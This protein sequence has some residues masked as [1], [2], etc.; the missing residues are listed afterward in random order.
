MPWLYSGPDDKV[1]QLRGIAA[2]EDCTQDGANV[3]SAPRQFWDGSRDRWV[4]EVSTRVDPDAVSD[5]VL[6]SLMR[7]LLRLHRCSAAVLPLCCCCASGG[8]S[9]CETDLL[10][11][12]GWV[13]AQVTSQLGLLPSYEMQVPQ[14]EVEAESE[15]NAK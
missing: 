7:H 1:C 6:Q 12:G 14:A 13:G 15:A 11:V 8:R 10:S 3:G 9:G 4:S 5:V 2:E